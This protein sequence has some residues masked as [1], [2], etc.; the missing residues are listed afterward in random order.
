V[1][2]LKEFEREEVRWVS[3]SWTTTRSRKLC[4]D[5]QTAKGRND[6]VFLWSDRRVRIMRLSDS[7]FVGTI[8]LKGGAPVVVE[9]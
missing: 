1:T 7:T 2:V 5:M 9:Q 4:I 6:L 3:L 8:I